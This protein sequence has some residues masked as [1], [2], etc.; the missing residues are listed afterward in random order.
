MQNETN[1]LP[2]GVSYTVYPD[3]MPDFNTWIAEIYATVYESAR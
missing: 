1:N 3:N 2:N